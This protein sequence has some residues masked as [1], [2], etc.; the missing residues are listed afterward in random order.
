MVSKPQN[1]PT[2]RLDTR[3]C[4]H[5]VEP[6]GNRPRA[7]WGPMVGPRGS[8]GR[9]K[10]IFSKV[11]PT[12]LGMLKQVILGCIEPVVACFGP[13]KSL[14][15][16]ENGPFRDQKWVKNGSKTHFSKS[17]LG[18][19]GMLKQA[20]LANFEP[21]VTHCGP[22]KIPKCLEIGL[23]WD[24]KWVKNGSKTCFANKQQAT[25]NKQQKA[26]HRSVL[27]IAPSHRLGLDSTLAILEPRWCPCP[28]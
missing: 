4:G 8:P 7:R 11:V 14:E 24:Q 25:S 13:R 3:T 15:C 26:R 9:K 12:P 23:F 19:F 5:L 21:V 18:P 10:N 17:D 16:L 27:A 2:R 6:E 22:C 20:F 1:H 28:I